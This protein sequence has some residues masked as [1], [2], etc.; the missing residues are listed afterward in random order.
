[1]M[2]SSLLDS[3]LAQGL[4]HHPIDAPGLDMAIERREDLGAGGKC[5]A[6]EQG[7]DPGQLVVAVAVVNGRAARNRN[8]SPHPPNHGRFFLARQLVGLRL[9]D[10]DVAG[11]LEETSTPGMASSRV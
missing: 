8:R 5:R 1:M 10:F 3:L 2:T 4:E 7:V 11:D 9:V 6:L